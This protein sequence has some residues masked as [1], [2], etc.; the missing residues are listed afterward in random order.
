MHALAGQ[1][2]AAVKRA[3]AAGWSTAE[4]AILIRDEVHDHNE[5]GNY[6]PHP[7]TYSDLNKYLS[8]K[9]L[10]TFSNPGHETV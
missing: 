3:K 2:D 10:D 7:F 5:R 8:S 9:G 1:L 4:I 6:N